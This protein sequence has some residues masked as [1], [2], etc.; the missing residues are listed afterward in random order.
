MLPLAPENFNQVK[1]E[2]NGSTKNV[3]LE[4]ETIFFTVVVEITL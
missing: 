4:F 2:F 3:F 1:D